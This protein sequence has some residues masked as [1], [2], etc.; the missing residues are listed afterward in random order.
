MMATFELTTMMLTS[1]NT[2]TSVPG[3]ENGLIVALGGIV[4][5][6]LFL[7]IILLRVLKKRKKSMH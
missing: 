1:V 7:T 3:S 6:V 4:A 5:V 2:T